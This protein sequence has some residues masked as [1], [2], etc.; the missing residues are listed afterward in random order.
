M[1]KNFVHQVVLTININGIQHPKKFAI[2]THK[3]RDELWCGCSS[4]ANNILKEN[5]YCNERFISDYTTQ[6][7][8]LI[9]T[10]F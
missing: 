4:N 3:T 5:M 8:K 7:Y 2:T 6:I 10:K 9:R 1:T